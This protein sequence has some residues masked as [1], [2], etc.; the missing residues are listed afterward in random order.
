[1]EMRTRQERVVSID[2]MTRIQALERQELD[3]AMKP[4]QL[5]K[6]EFEY[7]RHGTQ[8]LIASFDVILIFK[9]NERLNKIIKRKNNRECLGYLK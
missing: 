4:G 9:S 1:M 2:E 6:R 5:L 7:I 3:K 8:T